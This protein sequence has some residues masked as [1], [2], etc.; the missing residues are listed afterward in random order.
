MNGFS[1][2]RVSRN[3][4]SW[5]LFFHRKTLCL[6]GFIQVTAQKMKFSVKNFF[7][8]CDQIRSF[9]QTGSYLL[10]KSSMENFL[11]CTVGSQ[12]I[13]SSKKWYCGLFKQSYVRKMDMFYVTITGN[14]ELFQYFNFEAKFLKKENLFQKTVISFFSR[15]Y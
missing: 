5:F 1:F 4:I 6:R 7:S 8:K 14:F 15:K 13:G 9:L 11:F 2:Q 3:K 10:K 12:S